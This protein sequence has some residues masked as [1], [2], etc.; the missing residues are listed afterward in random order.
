METVI[1]KNGAEEVKALVMVTMMSLRHLEPI[2]LV[3]KCKDD[4]HI[5]WGDTEEKLKSL[6]LLECSGRPHDSI[7][8]IVLSALAGEGLDM[9][10]VS[11]IKEAT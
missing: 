5:F 9:R 7:R 8:N 1:L 10:L 6:A 4:T 11:P 3:Q 2:E